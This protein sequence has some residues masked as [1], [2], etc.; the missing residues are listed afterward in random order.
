MQEI[1]F[2]PSLA[3]RIRGLDELRGIA[4]LIVLFAHYSHFRTLSPAVEHFNLGAIG[5]DMFFMISGYLI[6]TILR[7]E[8]GHLNAYRRFYVRRI[9]RILPLFFV[10]LAMGTALAVVLRE[11]LSGL[12]CYLTFTQNL[13][14]EEPPMGDLLPPQYTAFPGLGPLWSLAVEEHTYLLLPLLAFN[15]RENILRWVLAVI[16]S[17]A[18]ILKLSVGMPYV[19][20]STW[21]IYTNP[22][23]TWF[24]FQYIAMG[25]LLALDRPRT[26]LS[27]IFTVWLI[28]I[29]G[30][31]QGFGILEWLIAVAMLSLVYACVLGHA[32]IRSRPLA[33]L[34]MLC[35]GI[36]LLHVFIM[37]G[38]ERVSIPHAIRLPLFILLS[39]LAAEIS[40]RIFEMP[41]QRMRGRFEAPRTTVRRQLERDFS[42]NSNGNAHLADQRSN[43]QISPPHDTEAG[44]PS[45]YSS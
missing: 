32:P 7:K 5:V 22:H 19:D 42:D 10:V 15:L 40:L 1:T 30:Y 2:R 4:I 26:A 31:G 9:F 27:L 43:N 11:S 17:V 25:A 21:L 3:Q 18:I 24:R 37:V 12:V 45:E 8:Q 33:R 38:L 6:M 20:S 39:Y 44:D 16:S 36:Y 29:I 34:G 14:A 28:A 41:I 23:E 35:Y 13:L